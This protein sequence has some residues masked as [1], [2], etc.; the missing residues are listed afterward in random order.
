MNGKRKIDFITISPLLL[1][2]FLPIGFLFSVLLTQTAAH[3]EVAFLKYFAIPL[4]GFSFGCVVLLGILRNEWKLPEGWL[5]SIERYFHPMIF[6]VSFISLICFSLLAVLRYTSLHTSVFDMGFYDNKI[7]RISVASGASI[8]YESAIGHFQPILISYGLIY[9]IYDSVVIIQILQAAATL[10]GIIPL[11]LIAKRYLNHKGLIFLVVMTYLLY[12]PI[13]FNASSDF[14]PDHLYLALL[15]WAFYFAENEN[16]IKAIIFV[17]L[18]A[19]IKEPLILGAA[20]FWLYLIFK[21][22]QYAI[23]VGVFL[24]FLF[25]FFL[26]VYII[27]PYTN[28]QLIYQAAFP[29]F[30]NNSEA[31]GVIA[32]IKTFIDSLLM[33]K[34][35]KM[36]FV[37]FL[38][39]P[40]L[41]LPL[42]EWKRFL[43]A[44][45]LIAIPLLSTSYPHASIDS[46]YTAGIVAPAFV[47]MFFSLKKLGIRYGL[48]I[49]TAITVF[50]F[51]MTITFNIAH[52]PTPISFSFWKEGWAEVW[53]K[54]NYISGEHEKILKDAI[55]KVS[56]DPDLAVVSQNNINDSR[57]AH[58]YRYYT[59]PHNWEDADYILLDTSKP[60]MM[61]DRLDRVGYTEELQKV[62]T[63][64]RFKLKYDRDGVI[65]FQKKQ[66]I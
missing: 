25:L 37:Y 3:P 42:L 27:L 54:S 6:T 43:P 60:P 8:F 61:G 44:I 26:V 41:F 58:R 56:E 28:K 53:H 10:S 65:L 30:E 63:D 36:L 57:L 33:W 48:K 5:S 11:T 66:G 40:L 46:Q 29:F 15:L 34:V 24:F 7:W 21:R 16:Y 2:I 14:H 23:G 31:G 1:L 17:A 39:A 64:P 32:R 52:S 20:F 13:G 38:L 4:V 45:P 35:R 59:F 49:T 18:S 51:I 19:M 47:A 9:K 22:K 50:V 62:R 12:P 55:N